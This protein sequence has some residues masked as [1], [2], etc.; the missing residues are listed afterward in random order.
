M[1]VG[2]NLSFFLNLLHACCADAHSNRKN[3]EKIRYFNKLPQARWKCPFLFWLYRG[4]QNSNPV[5][6]KFPLETVIPPSISEKR[7]VADENTKSKT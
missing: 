3:T 7:V 5:A 4:C 2:I 1:E 6:N